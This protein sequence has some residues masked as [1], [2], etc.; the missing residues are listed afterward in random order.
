MSNIDWRYL[1]LP[2]IML[3]VSIIAAVAVVLAGHQYEVIQINK[4]ESAV[5]KL[6][7]THRDYSET[8]ND[9]ALLEQYR[10]IFNDYKSSGLVGEERRLS[11]IESLQTTNQVLKLPL[12]TY[13]LLPQEKF[14]RP[15]LQVKS[16]VALNS[17]PM[18][19]SMGLLHEED[20]LAVLEGLRL[21]IKSLLTVESCL[22]RRGSH[23]GNSLDTVR[24]NLSSRCVIRWVT[25]DVK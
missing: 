11:W 10:S 22:L 13:N 3:L 4:F 24:P 2:L 15:G 8:V 14:T 16:D 20:L 21:S 19:L 7:K 23:I 25:I 9:I 17:S 1:K 6:R 5:S 18:E 12:L